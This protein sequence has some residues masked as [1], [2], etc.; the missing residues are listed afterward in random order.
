MVSHFDHWL[1]SLFIPEAGYFFPRVIKKEISQTE[2]KE[3]QLDFDLSDRDLMDGSAHPKFAELEWL[4]NFTNTLLVQVVEFS[5]YA[6]VK[7]GRRGGS[8]RYFILV[9]NWDNMLLCWWY[10]FCYW[11]ERKKEKKLHYIFSSL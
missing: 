1:I 4:H 8:F 9:L 10:R 5:K 2:R 7:G 11:P 3:I 6:P